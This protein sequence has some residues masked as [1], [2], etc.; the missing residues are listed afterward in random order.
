MGQFLSSLYKEHKIN[1]TGGTAVYDDAYSQPASVEQ[2]Y[3][4]LL[5]LS[6]MASAG[7][8]SGAKP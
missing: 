2:Q 7:N 3:C 5:F 4:Q 1:L 8:T 6:A